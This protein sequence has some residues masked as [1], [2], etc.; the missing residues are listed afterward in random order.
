MFTQSPQQAAVGILEGPDASKGAVL[1]LVF[2]RWMGVNL[3][4]PR[5]SK[6]IRVGAGA[7]SILGN[8]ELHASKGLTTATKATQEQFPHYHALL[9]SMC[10]PMAEDD[11][12][13]NLCEFRKFQRKVAFQI[14]ACERSKAAKKKFE[15]A[16]PKRY[17]SD[18]SEEETRAHMKWVTKESHKNRLGYQ[19]QCCDLADL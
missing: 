13:H 14:Q 1:V 6:H 4:L 5:W 18:R 16:K 9:C 11:S 19:V 2:L 12:E 15:L 17:E 3:D 8:H 10:Y 7:A